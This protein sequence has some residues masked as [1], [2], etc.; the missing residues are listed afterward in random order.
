[1]ARSAR[2][3]AP[4]FPHHVVQRGARGMQTFFGDDDYRLY[5]QLLGEACKKFEV[6]IWAYC[7]MPNHVHLIVTPGDETGLAKAISDTHRKYSRAVNKREDWQGH[8]WQERFWSCPLDESH[9]VAATRYVECNP[10]RAK[11]TE[12][13]VDWQW[14][15]AKVHTQ[16]KLEG[17]VD[18][19]FMTE[20]VSDWSAFLS[21]P[22]DADKLAKATLANKRGVP[23]GSGQF[24]DSIER[25]IGRALTPKPVGRPRVHQD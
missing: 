17:I 13:P 20:L 4:G 16:G 19:C 1:M 11:L 12:S 23:A 18:A 25:L 8:L 22:E 2:I 24:V 6:S 15:S 21:E 3:V 9:C 14:S 5:L 7:L 10:V